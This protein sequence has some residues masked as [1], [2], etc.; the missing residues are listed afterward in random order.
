MVFAVLALKWRFWRQNDHFWHSEASRQ[1]PEVF[2]LTRRGE[3]QVLRHPKGRAE[4]QKRVALMRA[5]TSVAFAP[6]GDTTHSSPLRVSTRDSRC[7]RA[8]RFN[9]RLSLRSR[10]SLQCRMLRCARI[11]ATRFRRSA[12]PFG[13]RKTWH[14]PLRVSAKT[15]GAC[16]A[17]A[18]A[19]GIFGSK[20]LFLGLPTSRSDMICDF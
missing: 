17:S 3:Y 9:S 16:G 5:N 4:R 18:F 10:R 8:A 6:A 1:A 14:S 13:C 15:S 2:A 20:R 7:A 11:I 12:R 19:S